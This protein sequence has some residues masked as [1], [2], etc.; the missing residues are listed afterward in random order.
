MVKNV[1]KAYA[2]THTYTEA[3]TKLL[4]TGILRTHTH[5]HTNRYYS[6]VQRK[7][8]DFL[9]QFRIKRLLV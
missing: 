3:R 7:N 9:R 6:D 4:H 8:G 1:H 2:M 5:T